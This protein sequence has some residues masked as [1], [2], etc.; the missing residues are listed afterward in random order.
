[1][2]FNYQGLDV[3]Y[4]NRI[5]RAPQEPTSSLLSSGANIGKKEL[6]EEEETSKR[7]LESGK[8]SKRDAADMAQRRV[9]AAK[10]ALGMAT[11]WVNYS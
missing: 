10:A 7:M 11:A 8:M 4:Y 9:G 5:Y 2:S 6:Q 1:M 3:L